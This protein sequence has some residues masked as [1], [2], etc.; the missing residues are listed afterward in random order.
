MQ[1]QEAIKR[2]L[3]SER[4]DPDLVSAAFRSILAGEWNPTQVAA[5]VVGQEL[6]G[7]PGAVLASAAREMRRAMIPLPGARS[8]LID[9]CGTGGDGSG[10][11]N[12]STGTAIL[13]AGAGSK[14][15]KHGNRAASSQSGSADVLERMGVPLT[16]PI[17][18]LPEVLDETGLVFLFAQH[19][20]P[21]LRHVGPARRELGVRTMFNCLGPLANPAGAEYHLL[22]AYADDLREKLA[23][24]LLEL[25]VRRAWVVRSEDGMDEMSPYAP[26]RVTEVAEGRIREFV[27]APE[28]FGLKRSP[29]GA[30]D[31]GTPEENATILLDVLRGEHHPS[32]DAFILS[33]AAAL[34]V[35]RGL[36]FTDA[37]ALAEKSLTSG[38]AL[39]AFERFRDKTKSLL[40][41]S[42]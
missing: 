26:T 31:G 37:A 33:A 32:R 30:I 7:A 25:G 39:S 38:A 6:R 10:S 9:T 16:V 4:P 23:R 40:P 14:V 20:H 11:L 36:S 12:L 5:Y 13:L 22:G 15:A 17:E 2:L 42:P 28:D 21:A 18:R 35:E 3:E 41:A 8:G 27:V 24:A 1:F 29:P 19:H 34:V